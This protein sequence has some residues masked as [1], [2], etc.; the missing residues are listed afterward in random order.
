MDR[1]RVLISRMREAHA[2]MVI[3][4]MGRLGVSTA[5]HLVGN[6]LTPCFVDPDAAWSMDIGGALLG[7]IHR[8]TAHTYPDAKTDPTFAALLTDL[9][10]A[11]KTAVYGERRPVVDSFE[12]LVRVAEVGGGSV[13]MKRV[14]GFWRVTVRD[15]ASRTLARG[16][17]PSLEVACEIVLRRRDAGTPGALPVPD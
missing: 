12:R 17:H 16:A 13:K 3:A 1:H 6:A 4:A 14:N 2:A 11:W 10:F 15:A 8:D 5:S 9:V 7:V